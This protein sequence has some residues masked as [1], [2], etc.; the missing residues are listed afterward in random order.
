MNERIVE[1]LAGSGFIQAKV[2]SAPFR[3]PEVVSLNC[4]LWTQGQREK[5]VSCM[6]RE[7]AIIAA[8]LNGELHKDT[9]AIMA[10]I[11]MNFIL[12]IHDFTTEARMKLQQAHHLI[13]DQFKEEA[14]QDPFLW[15]KIRGVKRDEFMQALRQKRSELYLHADSNFSFTDVQSDQALSIAR[16]QTIKLSSH[17]QDPEFW[18]KDKS[19]KVILKPVYKK[20]NQRAKHILQAYDQKNSIKGVD[21]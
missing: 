21:S 6:A 1:L 18:T 10:S 15:F 13:Y 7:A 17:V 20:V 5:L 2:S 11:E 14:N 19:I 16:H 4:E 3:R 12:S 9:E 8:L